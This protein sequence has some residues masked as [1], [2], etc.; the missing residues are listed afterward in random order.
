MSCRWRCERCPGIRYV[1][2]TNATAFSS[3]DTKRGS[4]H[5]DLRDAKAVSASARVAATLPR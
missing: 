3:T 4:K 5:V 1:S 2:L